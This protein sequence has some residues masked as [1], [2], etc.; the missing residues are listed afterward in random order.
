MEKSLIIDD[1]N[2]MIDKEEFMIETK[3][4]KKPLVT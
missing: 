1:Y 3:N 4:I 2:K